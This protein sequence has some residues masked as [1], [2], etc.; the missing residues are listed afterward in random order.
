MNQAVAKAD[1]LR[2]R[3]LGILIPVVFRNSGCSFSNNFNQA[4]QRQIQAPVQVEVVSSEPLHE[5]NRFFRVIEL[6]RRRATRSCLLIGGLHLSRYLAPKVRAQKLQRVQLHL[7][8]ENP[9]KLLFHC[10]ECESR[11]SSSLKFHKNVHIAVPPEILSEH[12]AEEGQSADVVSPAKVGD[13]VLIDRNAHHVG[14]TNV[15]RLR[16]RAGKISKAN[17]C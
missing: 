13:F 2:P 15:P 17:R 1:D 11:H 7:S 6:C 9:R 16:C 5:R 14:F 8:T 3:Y 10:K 12:R 4:D